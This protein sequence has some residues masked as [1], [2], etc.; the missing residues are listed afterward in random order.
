[1]IRPGTKSSWELKTKLN[2]NGA[3]CQRCHRYGELQTAKALLLNVCVVLS[4]YGCRGSC[5]R[6]FL[7]HDQIATPIV[8]IR[9]VYSFT[10][11]PSCPTM[12][13]ISPPGDDR[14]TVPPVSSPGCPGHAA[15]KPDDTTAVRLCVCVCD[16]SPAQT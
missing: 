5:P 6:L 1:M 13:A 10:R 7:W 12:G 11:P 3:V 15:A 16:H 2:H 9:R 14:L 8:E 4:L